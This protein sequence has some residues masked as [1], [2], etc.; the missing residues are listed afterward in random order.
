MVSFC[1]C[2]VFQDLRNETRSVALSICMNL[3]LSYHWCLNRQ[4]CMILYNTNLTLKRRLIYWYTK[5]TSYYTTKKLNPLLPHQDSSPKGKILDSR[6]TKGAEPELGL[7]KPVTKTAT[8]RLRN[9]SRWRIDLGRWKRQIL[10]EEKFATVAMQEWFFPRPSPNR[11]KEKLQYFL[12]LN[13]ISSG[14]TVYAPSHTWFQH[15]PCL[16]L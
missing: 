7:N 11:H 8:Q 15:L 5:S 6:A 12:V 2:I 4:T 9:G 1:F 10:R 3:C 14:T 16:L 13:K